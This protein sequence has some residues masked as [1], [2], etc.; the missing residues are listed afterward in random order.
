[1]K[2]KVVACLLGI[3]L[4]MANAKELFPESVFPRNSPVEVG[5]TLAEYPIYVDGLGWT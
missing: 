3:V 4:S 1:M 2:I 5:D